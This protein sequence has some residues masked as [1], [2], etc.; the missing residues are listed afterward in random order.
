MAI[1]LAMVSGT[2]KALAGIVKE[3]GRMDLYQRVLDLQQVVLEA[4]TQN[5]QL[6]SENN[7][8][9]RRVRDLEAEVATLRK[10][11]DLSFDGQVYWSGEAGEPSNGPYCPK[12]KD[13][14]DRRSRMIDKTGYTCC[15]VC[16]YCVDNEHLY[17][18]PKLK[19]TPHYRAERDSG[20]SDSW[21][22]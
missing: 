8:L 2:V 7:E 18:Y 22:F 21:S 4:V 6:A 5:T 14:K 11:P 9:S 10:G 20:G 19:A 12:C 1:D 15:P 17:K 3:A 13:G 16:D